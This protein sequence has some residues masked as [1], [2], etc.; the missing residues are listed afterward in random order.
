MNLGKNYCVSTDYSIWPTTTNAKDVTNDPQ[1]LLRY[2]DQTPLVKGNVQKRPF[3]ELSSPNSETEEIMMNKIEETIQR[4]FKTK[5][6]GDI[7]TLKKEFNQLVTVR[8]D[9]A[10]QAMKEDALKEV[11]QALKFMEERTRLHSMSQTD[12]LEQYNRRDNFKIFGLPWESNTV[13]VSM[14]GSIETGNDTIRKVM[15][16][17][18]SIDA[19]LSEND[20]SV[21]HRLPSRMDL[22]PVI[23]RF[24]RRVA[25]IKLLQSKKKLASLSG[26]N[27]V[28]T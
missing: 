20:V 25:K 19:G 28:K 2:P 27:D 9:E 15:D 13:G 26:L 7:E 24:S 6:S 21:G 4:S 14:N 3:L 8:V 12:F 5:L 16:V 18:N 1:I 10:V 11:K 23:V 22:K 17:S